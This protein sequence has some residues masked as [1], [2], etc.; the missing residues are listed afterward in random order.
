[1]RISMAGGPFPGMLI[2]AALLS[3]CATPNANLS[4]MQ[5]RVLTTRLIQGDREDTFRSIM[6]VLQDQGYSIRN[7][8][9]DAG[10]ISAYVARR[11]TGSL[12][13][14]A[15]PRTG[16][17]MSCIVGAVSEHTTE[18]RLNIRKSY[19][20]ERSLFERMRDAGPEVYDA[21]VLQN[22]FDQIVVEVKRRQAIGR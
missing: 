14:T 2:M 9:M 21:E 8:D 16:F 7:T 1:M 3:G 4:P 19:E 13:I 5:R 20:G 15:E 6:T 12:G 17:E 22:F 11:S 18:V 10:L